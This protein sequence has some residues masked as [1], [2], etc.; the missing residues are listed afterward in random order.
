MGIYQRD[1]RW[2]VYWHEN[3]KRRDKSFGR[4]EDGQLKAEA[5]DLAIKLA[6]SNCSALPDP[7]MVSLAAPIAVEP[8][9]LASVGAVV[10]QHRKLT[11]N[12]RPI[13]TPSN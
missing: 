1:E 9:G 7:A 6:R 5:F 11:P 8:S 10:K 2:M 3:G 4:G 13:L 12:Q